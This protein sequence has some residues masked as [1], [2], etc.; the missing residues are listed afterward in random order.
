MDLL[1]RIATAA[2]LSLLYVVAVPP[3]GARATA[4]TTLYTF[5]QHVLPMTG[6]VPGPGGALYGATNSTVY[7]LTQDARGAWHETTIFN[8]GAATIVGSP[9]AIYAATNTG[10]TVFE[11]T[12][13]AKGATR[14]TGTVLH[15]FH[16][17][18]DGSQ[19]L[20]LAL[21]PDGSLFGTTQL[22]GGSSVCG[23]MNGVPTGCGT[24][25]RLTK[26]KGKWIETI[27]HAFQ[28]GK[29]GAV[30][31]ASP[32]FDAA[33]NL[34]VTTS[35]GGT[36]AAKS[37]LTAPAWATA[38]RSPQ[39]AAGGCGEVLEFFV[40]SGYLTYDE[41]DLLCAVY[42]FVK[43]FFPES[44]PYDFSSAGPTASAGRFPFAAPIAGELIF[45]TT[46]GGN[47]SKFCLGTSFY[48]CG[49]VALLTRP[50]SGKTPWTRTV[51][52]EFAGPDGFNPT[53]YSPATAPIACSAS[54]VVRSE[55]VRIKAAARSSR[56]QKAGGAGPS[57]SRTDSRRTC[58]RCR[59]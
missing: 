40:F 38:H 10:N 9:A 36:S 37:A 7:E 25:F 28:G 51:L 53:G 18:K 56:S 33:G 12:P 24:L 11:L 34:Y 21:A 47:Q 59:S 55:A 14:W 8:A 35:E 2:T 49:A 44:E 20:G 23:S 57:A 19:P 32:T 26:S 4:L 16:G 15:A 52:H 29:D 41:V 58:S 42:N 5:P 46:G 54:R 30:P 1:R 45:T 48:G 13:P 31:V 6:L 22:G 39:D 43:L 50:S 17:G 27:L 3:A